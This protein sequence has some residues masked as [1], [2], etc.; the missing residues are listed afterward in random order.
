MLA[1]LA[2]LARCDPPRPPHDH[3]TTTSFLW[4]EDALTRAKQGL[5]QQHEQQV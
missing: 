3:T 1:T 2:T 4:E 5:L